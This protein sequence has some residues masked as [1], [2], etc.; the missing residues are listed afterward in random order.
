[1][2]HARGI[3][4]LK[5]EMMNTTMKNQKKTAPT[6]HR[7]RKGLRLPIAGEPAQ[8]ITPA[9]PVTQVAV[10]AV[11]FPGIRPR[12]AVVEGDRVARG[13]L[14]FEDRKN[15]GVRFT[16]PGA[17]TVAAIQRGERRALLSVIIT[18]D[19]AERTE[20]GT[21]A[22]VR[23]EAFKG[24]PAAQL[25][26]DEALGLL[27]ESGLFTAIRRRP[28]DRIPSPKETPRALFVMASGGHPLSPDPTVVV[29]ASPAAWAQGLIALKRLIGDAPL[30]VI[31]GPLGEVPVPEIPG[32]AVHRFDGRFP[33]GTPG[34]AM[35]VIDPVD[36]GRKA[37]YIGYQDAIAFGS[38]VKTGRPDVTR[39]VAL[40]GP[41][42][43]NPRLVRTRVGAAIGTLIQGEGR[44]G[45]YRVLSGSV[46]GGREADGGPLDFLGCYHDQITVIENTA[47]RRLLGWL[48]PG[49]DTFS[50]SRLFISKL[51]PKSRL[52]FTTDQKGGE[53]VMVPIGLFEK[54]WPFDLL[55]T[56]LLRALL[57]GDDETSEALGCLE[58]GEEDVAVCS[59]VCPSKIDYGAA[60]R[61][62]LDRIEE[63]G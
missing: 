17:G 6:I 38:L 19:D 36:R 37:W 53:R 28:F 62:T 8:K 4:S 22:S 43:A 7:T 15:K 50:V 25:T 3:W 46:L 57:A 29:A 13:T 35:H 63:Q 24:T 56:P 20:G 11:D 26:G 9:N 1:M 52:R 10:T 60:L 45:D 30:Y 49:A 18:L 58:L 61:S 54:V 51:M 39:V 41:G 12:M 14:L 40:S 23:F 21:P 33:F 31:L 44:A 47:E 5:I 2:T 55:V 27:T 59:F 32:V 16:S 48:A 42:V 34:S